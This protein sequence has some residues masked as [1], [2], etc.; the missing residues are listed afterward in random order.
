M[1]KPLQP[2]EVPNELLSLSVGKEVRAMEYTKP[3][4]AALL[5][6]INAVQNSQKGSSEITDLMNEQTV[7]AYQ[8]DE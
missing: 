1:P 6:A 2:T 5:P 8:A 7:G 4:I 3:N